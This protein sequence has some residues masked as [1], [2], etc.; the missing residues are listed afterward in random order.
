MI[1]LK[2]QN[3]SKIY[4]N[5]VV[6]IS[7]F[8]LHIKNREFIV[9]VGPSGCGKSTLLR[10]VAGL[11]SIT[12]G[13]LIL[14]GKKINDIPPQGRNLSFVFQNYA[15]YPHL[16]VY[17]NMAFNLKNKRQQKQVIKNRINDVATLLDLNDYLY[18]KP[19]ELSGGQQQR[20][21]LGRAIVS[22]AKLFLM[23]EPLSNLDAKL[24]TQMRTEIMKLHER[25]GTTTIY[26]TH[27]QTEAM[28]MATRLV[29]IKDG[30]IQQV[31]TPKDVYEQPVNTFVAS[32]I[33]SPAMNLLKGILAKGVIHIGN[34]KV[35]ISNEHSQILKN[36]GY[37]NTELIIGI[38][39]ED[40]FLQG[41]KQEID[42][43]FQMSINID[44][45]ESL[46]SEMIVHGIV[47]NQKIVAKFHNEQ[48]FYNETKIEV[49]V[50]IN[51]IH[52]FDCNSKERININ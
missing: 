49:V 42:Q 8:N 18:R 27:D 50:D 2:M 45:I 30:L 32:F 13:Q 24:R 37:N 44:V 43:V 17:N 25:L 12:S 21:A 47:D 7:D 52:F 11:E 16:N 15:L 22:D 10:L 48:T 36:Q 9:L 1:D 3:I 35:K 40:I 29:V 23:D 39:P 14:N 41:D 34:F 51:K 46:G 19:R 4:N 33:G 28:T 31:G 38:R 6:A 26:V 5:D 20:V